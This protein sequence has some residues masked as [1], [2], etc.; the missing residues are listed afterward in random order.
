MS[1]SAF[2]W[3]YSL[4]KL[5]CSNKRSRLTPNMLLIREWGVNLRVEH[6]CEHPNFNSV[7][8]YSYYGQENTF[9]SRHF[10]IFLPKEAEMCRRKFVLLSILIV[11][12]DLS[13]RT[14]E[15]TVD[16]KVVWSNIKL[17]VTLVSWPPQVVIK[18]VW[19]SLHKD[20]KS[21]RSWSTWFPIFWGDI[22]HG[23]VLV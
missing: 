10:P 20:V 5:R 3:I 16:H 6:L 23:C 12:I 4:L 8:I 18:Q 19:G 13:K 11:T 7:V 2:W 14:E 1:L 9:L 21:P 22:G 17:A 15:Y